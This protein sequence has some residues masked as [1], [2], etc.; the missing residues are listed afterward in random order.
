[1]HSH[2]ADDIGEELVRKN[3]LIGGVCMHSRMADDIGQVK[4]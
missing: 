3:T 4:S 1:M 2:M